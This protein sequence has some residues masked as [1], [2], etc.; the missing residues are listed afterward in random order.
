MTEIDEMFQGQ[1]A[2]GFVVGL[3]LGAGNL[4]A[5]IAGD[6]HDPVTLG[7]LVKLADQLGRG[8]QVEQ[9]NAFHPTADELGDGLHRLF[10]FGYETG[11]HHVLGICNRFQRTAHDLGLPFLD[12][13]AAKYKPERIGPPGFHRQRQLVALKSHVLRRPAHPH[14]GRLGDANSLVAVG[15]DCRNGNP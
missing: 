12:V 2:T 13:L 1:P 15:K 7:R 4:R 6:D 9:V 10:G 8:Y 11:L 5:A 3:D 14:G